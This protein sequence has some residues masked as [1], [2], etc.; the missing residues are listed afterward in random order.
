MT[1]AVDHRH[2]CFITQYARLR[3]IALE[4]GADRGRDLAIYQERRVAEMAV[5]GLRR[6]RPLHRRVHD[7]GHFGVENRV[8]NQ[9][10]FGRQTQHCLQIVLLGD[11]Q[12]G[13]QIVGA[14]AAED[15]RYL[16]VE[17]GHHSLVLEVRRRRLLRGLLFLR[18]TLGACKRIADEIR[19]AHTRI[20]QFSWVRRFRYLAQVDEHAGREA[21][22]QLLRGSAIRAEDA[23]LPRDD[24]GPP[25]H[26]VHH[27]D[28][29]LTDEL[30]Q[31][32]LWIEA[33][34]DAQVGL[35]GVAHLVL[36][37]VPFLEVKRPRKSHD[38]MGVNQS[39][40][41]G[42]SIQDRETLR[43]RHLVARADFR[44][45][46]LLDQHDAVLNGVAGDRVHR[47][48]DHRQLL[49]HVLVARSLVGFGR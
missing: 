41:H 33:V 45:L 34:H 39:R 6:R 7:D 9:V 2:R 48:R 18:V 13:H 42:G 46:A 24:V 44:D 17:H 20:G 15:D 47:P 30:Q 10:R 19:R 36:I 5:E 1:Q 14:M 3:H 12:S 27:R 32:F 23:G 35:I 16:F 4:G 28:A 49:R 31:R 11:A 29:V 8:G 22:L 21:N 40:R 26:R 38:G 37:L 25:R 43:H